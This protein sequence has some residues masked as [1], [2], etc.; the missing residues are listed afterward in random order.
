MSLL[1]IGRE[2]VVAVGPMTP[3]CPN[4]VTCHLSRERKKKGMAK[5]VIGNDAMK[6]TAIGKEVAAR[7]TVRWTSSIAA[8]FVLPAAVESLK[9][10]VF[11]SPGTSPVATV[12]SR[13]A[14]MGSSSFV[15][16]IIGP[17]PTPRTLQ[18]L[19]DLL[20]SLPVVASALTVVPLDTVEAAVDFMAQLSS[21][22]LSRP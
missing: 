22:D 13:C 1:Y 19:A 14:L 8:D 20:D 10:A 15:L 16:A 17:A 5:V 11:L 2:A 4:N 12:V 7:F 6:G 18:P 3:T 9:F 21:C